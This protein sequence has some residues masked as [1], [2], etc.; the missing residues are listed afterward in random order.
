MSMRI[1]TA[2]L[3]ML[4]A[5]AATSSV[6]G[7]AFLSSS[8]PHRPSLSPRWMSEPSDTS[9]DSYDSSIVVESE[10]YLP[11]ETESLVTSVMDSL[12]SFG[13]VSKE[14]RTAINEV[15][16]KLEAMN[17]TPN[18]TTSPLLNGVWEM[19]YAAG[20]TEDWAVPSPTR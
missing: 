7:F 16:L 20:Y 19:R 4:A 1:S 13:Q 3:V 9:F 12:P 11:T 15:L 5:S 14:T 8:A 10:A 2:S 18:P 17:P 6:N